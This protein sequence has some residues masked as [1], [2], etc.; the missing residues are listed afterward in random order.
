MFKVVSSTKLIKQNLF[1]IK[2]IALRSLIERNKNA[3]RLPGVSVPFVVLSTARTTHTDITVSN[4]RKEYL[5]QLDNT[6]TVDSHVNVLK[7]INLTLNGDKDQ[8][9]SEDNLQ[10]YAG[11]LPKLFR[12]YVKQ[13]ATGNKIEPIC[14]SLN[15]PN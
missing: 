3:K 7:N 15:L 12:P 5:I 6:F 2:H 1:Q 11:M 8:V 14:F 10:V 9:I 4:D 13:I